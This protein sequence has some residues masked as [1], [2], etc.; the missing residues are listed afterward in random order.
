MWMVLRIA[1]PC[2]IS[3]RSIAAVRSAFRSPAVRD[4]IPT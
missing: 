3:A 1:Q 2:T 4:H